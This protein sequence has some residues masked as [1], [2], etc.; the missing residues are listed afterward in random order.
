MATQIDTL[1]AQ[2]LIV[3]DQESKASL[4]KVGQ[5]TNVLVR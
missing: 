4:N 3:D 5:N 1:S 2:I